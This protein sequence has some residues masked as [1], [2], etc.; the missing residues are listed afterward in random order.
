MASQEQLRGLPAV[1]QVLSGLAHL[2]G[3]FPRRL[4]VDEIRRVLEGAREEIRAGRHAD[5]AS[6]E[7]RVE[8][9]LAKLETP[10]LRRVINATGVVL[11]TNLGRA[12][13]ARFGPLFG[14][15]NLEYDLGRGERGKRDMH[16]A[17]LLERL[18][19]APGIAVNNNAA[20]VYLALNELAAGFEVIV[21]RGE[22]IEIGDGF[23]IP[24]IMQRS[25]AVLRE[26]GTTNR[27]R[28]EDYRDAINERTRLL[29]RVH[30]SNFRIEGFT[31]RP[32]LR[33]LAALGRERGVPLYE[34][35][36]SGCVADLRA[37]GVHEPLVSDSL[38]SGINLVSFSG[39]KLLGGPQAGI[40]AGDAKLVARLRRNPMFRALRLDK[41]IYQA[42]E[43]TLRNLV[44]E[45]WDQIPALRMI[46][47]SSEE[48]RTRSR[49][50]LGRLDGLRAEVIQG[51]SM[52]GGGSTPGQPLGGWLV[53][54]DCAEI[55]EAE[56][57]LRAGD[58]PVVA[59]IED[60][61]L[62]FDLRTVFPSEEEELAL[63]ILR[64]VRAA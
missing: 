4:I 49:Q 33:E 35:L 34:D 42:L 52:I 47:Q 18:T 22:L 13:L 36:G 45:R 19:G 25:G 3:R 24:E 64:S 48:L 27:T 51:E 62:M 10:S 9:N 28:I 23:R 15:S 8:Q 61:R 38:R 20:A 11:H 59:R 57:R 21:S 12:P 55:V 1:D 50:L 32:E 31:A 2:E 30:P 43:T 54:I 7:A 46:A 26:V 56:R 41:L 17:E 39:D 29:L 44:L 16:V 40:L 37:F 14:Y 53:A 63:A 6:I 5:P 58:P 60:G